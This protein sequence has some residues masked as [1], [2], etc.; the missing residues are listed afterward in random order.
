[1]G[2]DL[3]MLGDHSPRA[4]GWRVKILRETHDLTLDALAE[5]VGKTR[6]A[7]Y[8][9]EAAK[10][11]PRPPDIFILCQNYGVDWNWLMAGDASGLRAETRAELR[12]HAENLRQA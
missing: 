1:M 3:F 12:K 6:N 4:V 7:V 10:S 11:Y 5:H 9:W 2:T 8:S